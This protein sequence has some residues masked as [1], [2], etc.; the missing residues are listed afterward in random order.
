MAQSALTYSPVLIKDRMT[1]QEV[2]DS[3]GIPTQAFI[4]WFQVEQTDTYQRHCSKVRVWD[5]G[6]AVICP[7]SPCPI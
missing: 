3:S 4:E 1:L 7:R 6:C 2:V 5:G